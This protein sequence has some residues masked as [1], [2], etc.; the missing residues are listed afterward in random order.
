VR[1]RPNAMDVI[2]AAVMLGGGKRLTLRTTAATDIYIYIYIY[3]FIFIYLY[4]LKPAA[5]TPP[6]FRTKNSPCCVWAAGHQADELLEA[7]YV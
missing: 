6:A 1:P 5:Q 2:E 3:I 4:T 7:H